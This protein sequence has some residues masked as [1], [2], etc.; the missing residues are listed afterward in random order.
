MAYS[1]C[2][3]SNRIDIPEIHKG[4]PMNTDADF[5]TTPISSRDIAQLENIELLFF[6]YRDFV[7][8][9]D[10]ILSKFGFGRAHHRVLYFVNRRPGMT[11]AELLEILQI[12]KQSLARVLRQLIDSGYIKQATGANDRRKRLLFPTQSGRDLVLALSNPQS[13]RIETALSKLSAEDHE[14]VMKFMQ[15]MISK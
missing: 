15:A 5:V 6:A 1:R 3:Y 4:R 12:T 11:V 2:V 13:K 14:T 7:G 8:D 10:R 9:A